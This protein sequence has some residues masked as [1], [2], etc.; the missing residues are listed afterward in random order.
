MAPEPNRIPPSA[1][2]S[3]TAV[4]LD[5]LDVISV[6]EVSETERTSILDEIGYPPGNDGGEHRHEGG[7]P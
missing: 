7:A 3:G 4:P 1:P 6:E 2:T 5:A